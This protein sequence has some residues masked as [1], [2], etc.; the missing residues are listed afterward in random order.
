[1]IRLL[2]FVWL[3]QGDC[4]G[5]CNSVKKMSILEGSNPLKEKMDVDEEFK[6][7]ARCACG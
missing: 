5:Y 1:M 3:V 2:M 4:R 6:F 7:F